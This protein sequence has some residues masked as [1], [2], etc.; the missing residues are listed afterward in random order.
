[1]SEASTFRTLELPGGTVLPFHSAP[2]ARVRILYG[3]IWMTEE[4]SKRDAFMA[5][6]EEV[7]LDTRGLAVIEALGPAR[8]QL[9]GKIGVTG[10]LIE[11]LQRVGRALGAS[12]LRHFRGRSRTRS[13]ASALLR[14]C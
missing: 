5:S 4:G 9:I 13:A 8:V 10:T 3:R 2:G 1:M 14:Q 12:L 11:G 7:A 6:G